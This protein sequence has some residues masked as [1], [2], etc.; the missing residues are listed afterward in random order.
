MKPTAKQIA[1]M[2]AG[3]MK[4]IKEK[5]TFVEHFANGG[6]VADFKPKESRTVVRPV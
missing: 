4:A 1:K 6:K 2:R 3:F 5:K